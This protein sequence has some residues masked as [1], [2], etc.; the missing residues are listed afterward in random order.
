MNF[1]DIYELD[2]FIEFCHMQMEKLHDILDENVFD[3]I[4]RIVN[5]DKN[6]K[7]MFISVLRY[8]LHVNAEHERSEHPTDIAVNPPKAFVSLNDF[9]LSEQD[10]NRV[11]NYFLRQANVTSHRTIFNRIKQEVA[12]EYEEQERLI[13]KSGKKNCKPEYEMLRRLFVKFNSIRPSFF[14]RQFLRHDFII[15]HCDYEVPERFDDGKKTR[16]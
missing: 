6:R 2:S 7:I 13:V 12:R 1:L 9:F 16:R 10:F 4:N 8:Y 11:F 3:Q 5:S 15:N 14:P